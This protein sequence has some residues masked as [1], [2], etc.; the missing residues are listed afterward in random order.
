MLEERCMQQQQDFQLACQVK[1]QLHEQ[2]QMNEGMYQEIEGLKK[3][4]TELVEKFEQCEAE[5]NQ[6]IECLEEHTNQ[7][8]KFTSQLNS[9][10][11]KSEEVTQDKQKYKQNNSELTQINLNLS[12]K[13]DE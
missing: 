7:I 2:I 4:N 10:R 1:E 13:V 5:K 12:K 9:E 6:L 3:E 8:H 11:F